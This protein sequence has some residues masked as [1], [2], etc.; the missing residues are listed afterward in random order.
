[1]HPGLRRSFD[2]LLPSRY[3][4]PIRSRLANFYA[5]LDAYREQPQRMVWAT[6]LSIGLEL[7]RIARTVVTAWAL[8]LH[9]PVIVFIFIMP[10][11]IFLVQLPIHIAGLGVREAAFIYLFGQVG[12]SAAA[13][14]AL[15]LISFAVSII[16]TIL[17]GAWL[18]ASGRRDREKLTRV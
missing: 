7:L 10:I 18:Y 8:G 6:A 14:L 13:A 12:M 5:C 9:F 4:L 16:A 1:M 17:P 11:I 3:R 2:H 15:S